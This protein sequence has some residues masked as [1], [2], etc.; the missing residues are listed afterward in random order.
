MF[1]GRFNGSSFDAL[2]FF[3]KMGVRE[4]RPPRA[5]EIGFSFRFICYWVFKVRDSML[6]LSLRRDSHRMWVV[7]LFEQIFRRASVKLR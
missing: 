5:F 2:S 7:R 4:T 3:S 6:D 1:P